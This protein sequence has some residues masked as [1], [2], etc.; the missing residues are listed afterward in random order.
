M[1]IL[2]LLA[3]LASPVHLHAQPAPTAPPAPAGLELQVRLDRSGFS[4]GEIDGRPGLVTRK[5]LAAFQKARKLAV[6]G[7]ADKATLAALAESAPGDTVVSYQVTA[8]DVAGPFTAHIPDDM[9]ERAA[10]PALGYRS[11]LEQLSERFH[12]SPKLL[13]ALNPTATFNTAGEALQVPHV[14]TLPEAPA[15]GAKPAPVTVTVSKSERALTVDDASGQD[16][17][18]LRMASPAV[19]VPLKVF[20]LGDVFTILVVHAERHTRQMERVVASIR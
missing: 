5:A 11:A 15:K 12:V 13:S 3:A 18:R 1:R 9:M 6:T 14:R 7:R 10:L 17:R 19:P 4:P 8:E 16:W 20:N 2:V